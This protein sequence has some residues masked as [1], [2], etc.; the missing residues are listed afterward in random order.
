[1]PG[2]LAAPVRLDPAQNVVEVGWAVKYLAVNLPIRRTTLEASAPID[3]G[4]CE[5]TIASGGCSQ[6]D[7][8]IAAA[9]GDP[10]AMSWGSSKTWLTT[11]GVGYQDGPAIAGAQARGD[12][13]QWRTANDVAIDGLPDIAADFPQAPWQIFDGRNAETGQGSQRSP[14]WRWTEAAGEPV[15]N[16]EGEPVELPSGG[17]A[18]VA[19]QETSFEAVGCDFF[20]GPDCFETQGACGMWAMFNAWSFP[21]QLGQV[22]ETAPFSIAG[23]TATY[24]NMVF[25]PVG[26]QRDPGL[27][28]LWILFERQTDEPSA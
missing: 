28:E 2:S 18:F 4:D 1:M 19:S 5:G 22:F 21:P 20:F 17:P 13:G 23:M 25:V 3:D 9:Q 11:L 15:E 12:K 24:R 16:S 7:S 27:T 10:A 8:Q 14:A 26:L 6:T